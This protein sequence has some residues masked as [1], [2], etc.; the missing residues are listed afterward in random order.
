MKKNLPIL[1]T[2]ASLIFPILAYG[3]FEY[4]WF[5][6][7]AVQLI[8]IALVLILARVLFA[9]FTSDFS[10]WRNPHGR[11]MLFKQGSGILIF[12]FIATATVLWY[13]PTPATLAM[14]YPTL[15]SWTVAGAF[16]LS[17]L[18][19]PTILERWVRRRDPNTLEAATGYLHTLTLIW[20]VWLLI[21]GSIALLL[22]LCG[23]MGWWALYTGCL[24]YLVMAAL[25]GGEWLF[26]QWWRA[27]RPLTTVPIEVP[28][29]VPVQHT[30]PPIKQE[31]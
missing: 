11:S 21:N 5:G 18:F 28:K 2:I 27:R 26:R 29:Q 13:E 24:S 4:S 30:E 1:L 14:L 8:S 31:Q 10:C 7:D 19:P 15:M 16:F 6:W 25:L 22:A 12:C 23:H 9:I 20:V 17:W 3:V